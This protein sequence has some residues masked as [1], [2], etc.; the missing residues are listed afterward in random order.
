MVV[1]NVP[2]DA[3]HQSEELVV[4]G[5]VVIRTGIPAVHRLKVGGKLL[6]VRLCHTRDKVLAVFN[7][8]FRR[9]PLMQLKRGVLKF[10]TYEEEEFVL[11]DWTAECQSVDGA[12]DVAAW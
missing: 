4:A 7:S 1:G 6:H 10:G 3:G 8:V 9:L 11:D 12:L 2:V 5:E